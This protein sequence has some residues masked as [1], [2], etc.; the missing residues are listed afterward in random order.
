MTYPEGAAVAAPVGMSILEVS[1]LAHRPHTAICGGRG[2]CTTCRVRVHAKA[3]RLPEPG[4]IEAEALARIQA[5]EGLRLACQLRPPQDVLAQPLVKASTVTLL[6]PRSA[7]DFGEERLVTVF[8]LDVRG[9]TK[10]AEKRL[11]FDVVFLMSHFFAE[12]AEAVERAGGHYSNFT[13]DGLMALFGLRE[14]PE[15]RRPARAG[16]RAR[17]ARAARPAERAALERDRGAAG[18]RRRHSHGRGDRRADGPA[19]SRRSSPR[20]GDTVNT[21][22]RLE[23]MTKELG[24]PV[25]VSEATLRGG[26]AAGATCPCRTC[27]CAG[28]PAAADRR[29]RSRRA[30]A[31]HPL[32]GVGRD[33]RGSS[34]IGG[35]DNMDAP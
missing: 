13:G 24:V 20:S 31:L 32:R 12:M 4:E 26:R 14:A 3:G 16:L 7:Q 2:R 8:F 30:G 6:P 21:T 22:A 23:S 11:P 35:I 1:R 28:G 33:G 19:E 18:D 25:V 10:L 29:A 9:S 15:S 34:R 5:P 27:C 17:Y